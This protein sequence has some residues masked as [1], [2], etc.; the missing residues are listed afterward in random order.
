MTASG[1]A[2]PS[3]FIELVSRLT[4]TSVTP[5]TPATAFSTLAEHA[6][7]PIPLTE[8]FIVFFLSKINSIKY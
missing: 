4:A 8:Y 3:T 6:A 2:E 1:A 5:S 7:Q